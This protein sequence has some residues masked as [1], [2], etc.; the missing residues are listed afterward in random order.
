MA[1]DAALVGCGQR[2]LSRTVKAINLLRDSLDF[3]YDEEIALGFF[4][5][6]QYCADQAR[7]S[8]FDHVADLLR[9]LRNTWA[10]V[11]DQYQLPQP[12]AG[13]NPEA[14]PSLSALHVAA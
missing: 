12:A 5:L 10:Q 2:D 4:R 6:Y 7:K 8:E 9:E 11:L 14:Q 1:Y 3:S 13:Q